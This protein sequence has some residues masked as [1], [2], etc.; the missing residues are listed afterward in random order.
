MFVDRQ[1]LAPSVVAMQR[2]G[3]QVTAEH[4]EAGGPGVHQLPRDLRSEQVV[5]GSDRQ[6]EGRGLLDRPSR[7]DGGAE[8]Q[9]G[10]RPQ[11]LVE[12]ATTERHV[13]VGLGHLIDDPRGGVGRGVVLALPDLLE[14]HDIGL[15]SAEPRDDLVAAVVPPVF[16]ERAGVELHD[17]E[18]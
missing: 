12:R 1:D 4:V 10:V 9:P 18:S 14:A 11:G 15:Q 2:S 8:E 7:Q 17:T 13:P 3:G 6:G 5:V 16:E